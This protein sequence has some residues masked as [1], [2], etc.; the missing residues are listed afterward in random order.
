MSDQVSIESPR[1]PAVWISVVHWNGG[2]ST[3]ACLESV[4]AD[5]YPN[6]SVVIVDNAST[7]NALE[8]IRLRWP[9]VAMIRNDRNTGFTGGQNQGIA[10]ARTHGAD[11]V[12]LL[13]Q[14][15]LVKPGCVQA[16]V[17]LATANPRAGLIS[18][19]VYFEDQPERV[20]FSGSWIDRQSLNIA[21]SY[22]FAAV[23]SKE[24]S[25]PSSMCLW[26]TALMIRMAVID[27]I[28]VLDE[29]FFAYYEDSD[30][31]ARASRAGWLNRMC[32]GAG[33]LHEG[34]HSSYTRPPHFWY[35]I[36][37]N[38]ILFWRKTLPR[39]EYWRR[40]R[41][42]LSR[43]IFQAANFQNAVMSDH[44]QASI[45]GIWD[46][47][48]RRYGPPIRTRNAPIVFSK[49]IMK[50]PYLLAAL[51]NFEFAAIG[52]EINSRIRKRA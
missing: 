27:E 48:M 46:G 17:D 36:A 45:D 49:L 37:R 19:V 23:R 30:Y 8:K 5:G 31:S 28:G 22:D 44:V 4:F 20:Q 41:I 26:G 21:H 35:L 32:F 15:A 29:R 11:F 10:H 34:H 13:N 1:A 9:A 16:M 42:H 18:P 3:I 14:D 51:L 24:L 2:Q 50:R 47:F 43:V 25:D 39:L 12:V 6:T 40:I 52:K 38:G 33:I 7:D